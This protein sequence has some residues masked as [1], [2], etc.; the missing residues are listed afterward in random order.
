VN[1]KKLDSHVVAFSISSERSIYLLRSFSKVETFPTSAV[2]EEIT[3]NKK[4]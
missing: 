1:F 3:L 4:P 2:K